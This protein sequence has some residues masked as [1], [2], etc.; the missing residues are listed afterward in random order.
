MPVSYPRKN[1]WDLHGIPIPSV[2]PKEHEIFYTQ[3]PQSGSLLR[4]PIY[5]LCSLPSAYS[6]VLSH[7]VMHEKNITQTHGRFTVPYPRDSFLLIFSHPPQIPISATNWRHTCSTNHS[8][9]F[10]SNYPHIDFAFVD[11]VITRY[12][13][14]VKNDWLDWLIEFHAHGS[15]GKWTLRL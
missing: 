3:T 9:T 13:S 2:L 7:P 8:E 1:L 5:C 4:R 12:S 6:T 14:H 11:S 10:C 15:P